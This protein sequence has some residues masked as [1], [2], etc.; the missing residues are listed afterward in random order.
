VIVRCATTNPGKLREFQLAGAQA[1]FDVEPLAGLREIP[2]PDETGSTF[3]ENAIQKALYYCAH[4]PDWLFADDSGLEVDALHGEPGVYSARYAGPVA[5]DV[6][7]DEANNRLLIE[8]LR[9]ITDRGAQFV[10]VIALT[11]AGELVKTFRGVVRG[12]IIDTP[13]GPNGF[14]YDPLFFHTPFGCTFGDADTVAK[15]QVSHR[16]QALRQ[17]FSWLADNDARSGNR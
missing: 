10:C 13:S 16:A 12:R 5:S 6:A 14:G 7:I 15:M 1:S 9:G 2:A 4:T 3:E 11:R 8:R 17:M